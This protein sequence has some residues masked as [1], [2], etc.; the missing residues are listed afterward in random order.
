MSKLDEKEEE[1]VRNMIRLYA[2]ELE[3]K[4]NFRLLLDQENQDDRCLFVEHV[5][6]A[7]ISFPRE[8]E[9]T[10][11]VKKY[12]RKIIDRMA[13]L[14]RKVSAALRRLFSGKQGG[15]SNIR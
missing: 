3:E 4:M 10:E 1:R 12:G 15:H 7:D 13:G 11:A 9:K 2:K 5:A 6:A 14:F 8:M